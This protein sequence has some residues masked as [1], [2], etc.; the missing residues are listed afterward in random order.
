MSDQSRQQAWE[1]H[2]GGELSKAESCYR[3]LIEQGLRRGKVEESDAINLGALLRQLTRLQDAC[4]HYDKSLEHLKTS[5]GLYINAINTFIEARNFGRAIEI[6]MIGIRHLPNNPSIQE[7]QGR[8]LIASK[9]FKKAEAIYLRLIEQSPYEPKYLLGLGQSYFYQNRLKDAERIFRSMTLQHPLDPRGHINLI[10]TLK[11]QGHLEKGISY[12]Q[13]LRQDLQQNAEIL[14]SYA[15]LMMANQKYNLA[16]EILAKACIEAPENPAN[17][18][19]R[20]AC[21][22]S[23]KHNVAC[24]SVIKKGILNH[25]QNSELREA[26]G[27]SL[28]ELGRG[29]AAMKM[30]MA[31]YNGQN[32]DRSEQLIN[33]QFLGTGYQLLKSEELSK[34]AGQWETIKKENSPGPLWG[35]RQRDLPQQRK[36]RIGYLSGDFC[37]HPVGRFL[38]PV[39]RH[40]DRDS[41]TIFGLDLCPHTDHLH[42]N[43]QQICD[44]WIDLKYLT[45]LTAARKIAD[46]KLDLLVELGGFTGLSRPEILVHRPA[47]LQLSYLGYCGPTYLKS[48]DGWVG[49]EILFEGLNPIDRNAHQLHKLNGGYMAY[50]P[51]GLPALT[52]PE[53]DRPFRFGCF[54]HSRKLSDATIDLFINVLNNVPQA[55][56]VLK[57]IT[58]VEA[59]EQERIQKRFKKAGLNPKRLIL[60]AWIQGWGNHM[61]A[62]HMMDVALDP[63]PYSGATTSCEALLMGVPVITLAGEA[64]VER[65]SSSV[66]ASAGKHEWIAKC[67]SEYIKI[68][69][70][71]AG[72][73]TK[74]TPMTQRL[75]LRHQVQKSNLGQPLRVTREL[76]MLYRRLC[77]NQAK[78]LYRQS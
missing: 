8:A 31:T 22:R 55:E 27:Q 57:S 20:S 47:P 25:P 42:A 5:E 76:E 63:T 18:L 43:F 35:D 59:A 33:I 1:L 62:Y 19:N 28:A 11:E 50:E 44:H 34:I 17:W 60:Q 10:T 14:S 9:Q 67:R 77:I 52:P 49:D 48:I 23:L 56:L 64:M 53:S 51:A 32:I 29:K 3:S 21:L 58:F 41:Y 4:R 70:R 37:N 61:T 72:D 24:H 6:G 78:L 46:L 39:L 30:L 65:L 26:F 13:G 38:L 54:N 16:E 75:A 15:A 73:Q 40:H 45:D 36:L 2:R 66:L 71:L 74:A 12:F 7:A 69:Q 68:A